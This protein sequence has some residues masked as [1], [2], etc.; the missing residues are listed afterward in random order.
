VQ[1]TKCWKHH[2]RAAMDIGCVH[3]EHSRLTLT[4]AG[5]LYFRINWCIIPETANDA[6]ESN[7]ELPAGTVCPTTL[8]VR[9][10]KYLSTRTA[11]LMSPTASLT[12][13]PLSSV[14]KL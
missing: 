2:D 10:A 9:P 4:T 6:K 14:S 3:Q 5:L 12:G 13:F 7:S 8:S 1:A 11:V